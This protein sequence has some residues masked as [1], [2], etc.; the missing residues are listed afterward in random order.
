MHCASLEQTKLQVTA[1]TALG[2]TIE[3]TSG[4]PT[5]AAYPSFLITSR[6][7]NPPFCLG[8][9]VPSPNS[10]AASNC[11]IASHTTSWSTGAFN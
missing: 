8:L 7:V 3:V 6:L 10:R 11:S 9:P 5:A 1:S 2:A 4:S